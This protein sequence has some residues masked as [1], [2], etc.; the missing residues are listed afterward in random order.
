M[1]LTLPKLGLGSPP[2]FSKL[3]SLILGGQN[4]SHWSILY[5]IG[6]LSKCKCRKWVHMGHLD[7][8]STSYGKNKGRE[9]NWQFD[10][11]PLKVGNRPNPGACKW[12]AIHRWKDLKDSYK[13]ALKLIPIEGMRKE[14]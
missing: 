9:S 7:I 6:K 3:Q 8:C 12:S 13:F 1:K 11:R 2:G 4:T 14:L 10:F 5:I